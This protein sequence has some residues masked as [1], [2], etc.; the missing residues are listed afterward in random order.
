MLSISNL[1][2][3]PGD[4]AALETRY[5]GLS[6]SALRN[7]LVAIKM[8]ETMAANLPLIYHIPTIDGFDGGLLPTS[9]YTAFTA[10]ILPQGTLRTIDGR[11]RELLALPN[12]NGACIPDQRWLDLTD[13]RYLVTD[14]VY[15]LVR[16]GIFYDTQFTI[17][18]GAGETTAI[19]DVPAFES[20][21]IDVLYRCASGNT[22]AA[23]T[24]TLDETDATGAQVT[25]L[26]GGDQLARLTL[27]APLTPRA[28]IIK[29]ADAV[30]VRAVTFVDTRTGDFQQLTLGPWRRILSSD[31]K[32][33]ENLDVMPRVFVAAQRI[34]VMDDDYGTEYA[35]AQMRDLAYDPAQTVI[36]SGLPKDQAATATAHGRAAITAYTSDRVEVAVDAPDGGTLVLSDAYYPGWTATV[37]GAAAALYRAD[38]MFR[39]VPLTA[40]RHTV[41][42][43]YKPVWLPGALILGGI[44]WLLAAALV[45]IA[46]ALRR[47]RRSKA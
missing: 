39:G 36:L 42:F 41:V 7:A 26:D 43:E 8:K 27:V 40:G 35:L 16:D 32:L 29:A 3:D 25:A 28:V 47:T 13:T 44:F 10:L 22:C 24:A 18:L 12:C 11:L 5:S 34:P 31:I 23:P 17:P 15:D 2:F 30:Q 19:R 46:Y 37:D 20:T 14:K 6:A 45:V 1:F 21:A 9:Y 33:Y 38:V 4:R